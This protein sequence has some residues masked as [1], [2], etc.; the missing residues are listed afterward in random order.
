MLGFYEKYPGKRRKKQAPGK[1]ARR[2]G[3]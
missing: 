1:N 3:V 2:N